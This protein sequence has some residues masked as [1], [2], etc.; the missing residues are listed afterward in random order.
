MVCSQVSVIGSL[1]SRHSTTSLDFELHRI[2]GR[3][4]EMDGAVVGVGHRPCPA[5]GKRRPCG[6]RRR[7]RG[8]RP[9]P[10]PDRRQLS[11]DPQPKL[12]ITASTR[13]RLQS[14]RPQLSPRP[15]PRPPASTPGRFHTDPDRTRSQAAATF[16]ASIGARKNAPQSNDHRVSCSK[17]NTPAGS[18]PFTCAHALDHAHHAD[19][20]SFA[21]NFRSGQKFDCVRRSQS[22]RR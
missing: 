7:K 18:K 20:A 1:R 15:A 17:Q 11:T 16:S 10:R 13:P 2:E 12:A 4:Q 22:R 9:P 21:E 6:D 14:S 5:P 3:L 8:H 19:P